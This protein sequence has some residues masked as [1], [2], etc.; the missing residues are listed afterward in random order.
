MIPLVPKPAALK[1]RVKI[2][3][4]RRA[5]ARS[6]ILQRRVYKI[7]NV[8]V[9]ESFN[10]ILKIQ[11]ILPIDTSL[12]SLVCPRGTGGSRGGDRWARPPESG[13]RPPSHLSEGLVP[14][15]P[16]GSSDRSEIVSNGQKAGRKRVK[17]REYLSSF[18]SFSITHGILPLPWGSL[19]TWRPFLWFFENLKQEKGTLLVA[20]PDLLIGGGEGGGLSSKPWGKRGGRA[21]LLDS[22]LF[23]CEYSH[24]FSLLATGDAK[25]LSW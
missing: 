10:I 16:R 15:L 2:T 13:W 22:P 18:P 1:Y 4:Y 11:E 21:P 20:D 3:P 24:L 6:T 12:K 5:L 25:R 17:V 23:A 9:S 7:Y 14:P 8:L 19:L